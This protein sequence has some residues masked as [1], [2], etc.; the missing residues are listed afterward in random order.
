MARRYRP[1]YRRPTPRRRTRTR[2][3]RRWS[4]KKRTPGVYYFKRFSSFTSVVVNS[5]A[6]NTF[7]SYSFSLQDI[8]DY[9]DFTKLYDAFKINRV[10]IMF[11][12]TSNV[13]LIDTAQAQVFKNTEHSNRLFTVVDYNDVTAPTTV[14]EL[15][16]YQACKFTPNNR[17]HK[18]Y[19]KPRIHQS[20]GDNTIVGTSQSSPW[21]SCWSSA[22][23]EYFGL[24]Y[25]LT[26]Q[27]NSSGSNQEVYKVE[28]ISYLS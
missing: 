5:G 27:T 10:K 2:K 25:A 12:P 23:V 24:K 6:S 15:R 20:V 28:V 3:Y 26:H 18:R 7:G 1:R 22:D 8:P 11:I 16:Q 21:L 17:T 14:D 4:Q 19:F 13:S 9:T